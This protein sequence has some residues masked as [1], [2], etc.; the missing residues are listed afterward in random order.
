MM[1]FGKWNRREI[2]DALVRYRKAVD[3]IESSGLDY[4]IIRPAWLTDNVPGE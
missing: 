4:T 2:G 3:L 1:S